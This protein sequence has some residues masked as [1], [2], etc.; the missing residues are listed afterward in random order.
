MPCFLTPPSER[1]RK[2][3]HGLSRG[4][5]ASELRWY[6]DFTRSTGSG[7]IIKVGT[8]LSA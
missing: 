8:S 6:F 2:M 4:S 7:D 5:R 1:R 3:C